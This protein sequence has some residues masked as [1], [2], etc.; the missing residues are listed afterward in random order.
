M[1]YSRVRLA[2]NCLSSYNKGTRCFRCVVVNFS[3]FK[4]TFYGFNTNSYS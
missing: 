4:S 3:S 1:N 2:S